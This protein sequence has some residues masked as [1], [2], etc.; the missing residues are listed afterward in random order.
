[1]VA[2]W[3]WVVDIALRN[4]YREHLLPD[5]VFALLSLP[6]ST[7]LEIC[8]SSN[9]YCGGQFGQLLLLTFCAAA[10]AGA[11]LLVTRWWGRRLSEK[12]PS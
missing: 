1:V 7:G 3:T 11:L 8:G 4:S 2:A 9:A 10:Q 6:A 12:R 5:V